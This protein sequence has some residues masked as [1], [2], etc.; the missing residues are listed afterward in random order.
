MPHAAARARRALPRRRLCRSVLPAPLPQRLPCERPDT[1]SRAEATTSRGHVSTT[2]RSAP[3]RGV[4]TPPFADDTAPPTRHAMPRQMQTLPLRETMP[5]VNAV[6]A[7]RMLAIIFRFDAAAASRGNEPSIGAATRKK[8]RGDTRASAA[9]Q[10]PRSGAGYCCHAP[11][12]SRASDD[13]ASR[14]QTPRR[15]RHGA[16][17]TARCRAEDARW[18]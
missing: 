6:C 14:Q 8:A 3:C 5:P 15:R 10:P 17:R 16:I 1:S 11:K 13:A 18:R 12:Q 2:C 9:A 7:Q 4:V